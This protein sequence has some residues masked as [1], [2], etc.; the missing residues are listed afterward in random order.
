MHPTNSFLASIRENGNDSFYNRNRHA[1]VD[2]LDRWR[3]DRDRG[4]LL[5]APRREPSAA[6]FLP[7]RP[8]RSSAPREL[9]PWSKTAIDSRRACRNLLLSRSV[10]DGRRFLEL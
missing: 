9:H 5:L 10:G 7:D 4:S 3:F 2:A 6:G 1:Q 8:R